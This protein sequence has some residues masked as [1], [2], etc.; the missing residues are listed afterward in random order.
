VKFAAEH[1]HQ[2]DIPYHRYQ[3][4]TQIEAQERGDSFRERAFPIWP[5]EEP[6]PYKVVKDCR[7][8][9]NDRREQVIRPNHRQQREHC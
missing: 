1:S 9:G 6:M 8:D 5:G 2:Q 4:V 7:L 3:T